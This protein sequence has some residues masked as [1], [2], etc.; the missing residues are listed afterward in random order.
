[1]MSRDARVMI[2]LSLLLVPTAVYGGLTLLGIVTGG[3]YGAPGPQDLS[4]LQMTLYRAGHAHA[5]VLLILS[6]VLQI[7]LDHVRLGQ[8]AVWI[9][10]L[11]APGAALLVS[12]GFFGIAHVAGLKVMLYLGVVCVVVATVLTGVGL[13]RRPA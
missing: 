12:G 9:G 1:M 7:A 13:L 8:G 3:A 2:G 6:L 5:G 10:R 11:T 4:P